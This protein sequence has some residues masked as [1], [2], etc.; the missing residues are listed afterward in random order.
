MHGTTRQMTTSGAKRGAKS[1][2]PCRLARLLIAYAGSA[3]D[4]S[5]KAGSL[6][7]EKMLASRRGFEPLL[8]P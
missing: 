1:T 4:A 5:W 6:K 3:V 2:A 8:P 7:S